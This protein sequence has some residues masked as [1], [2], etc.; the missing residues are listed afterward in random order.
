MNKQA[1]NKLSFKD[2]KRGDSVKVTKN[3]SLYMWPY[4]KLEAYNFHKNEIYTIQAIAPSKYDTIYTEIVFKELGTRIFRINNI[5]DKFVKYDE[6][7]LINQHIERLKSL[8]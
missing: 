4:G 7:A 5:T 6:F 1:N 2:L 3:M 8:N